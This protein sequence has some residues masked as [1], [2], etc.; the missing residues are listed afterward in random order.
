[1]KTAASSVKSTSSVGSMNVSG[2]R[3][4]GN[5]KKK[6][7]AFVVKESN[8]S[9]RVKKRWRYPRGKHSAVRQC[10]R[11]R[12]AMPDPGYGAPAASRGLH[13]TGLLPVVIRNASQLQDLQSSVQGAVIA[14]GTGD[15]KRLEI[16]KSAKEKKINILNIKDIDKHISLIE[17]KQAERKKAK[18]ERLKSRSKKQEEK[19][20]KVVEKEK[21]DKEKAEDKKTEDKKT[22]EDNVEQRIKEEEEKQK[23]QKEIADKTLTKR[24]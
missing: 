22:K 12:P 17:E 4:A 8:F 5:K 16:L 13:T 1:M 10:H 2:N 15:R 24:Q 7:P 9:A 20:K 18:A 23:E 6:K 14:S 19:K 11:G 3:K 21:K